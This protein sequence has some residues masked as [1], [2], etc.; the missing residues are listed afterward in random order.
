MTNHFAIFLL[1]LGIYVSM[2]ILSSHIVIT[3]LLSKLWLITHL[4]SIQFYLHSVLDQFIFKRNLFINFFQI[5][6]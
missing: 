4:F 3:F 2:E 1:E 6:K 5:M